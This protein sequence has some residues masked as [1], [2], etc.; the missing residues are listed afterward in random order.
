MIV[1]VNNGGA[2]S[3]EYF[4][5]YFQLL[6]NARQ[7]NLDEA[8]QYMIHQF[9]HLDPLSFGIATRDKYLEALNDLTQ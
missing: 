3:K 9:F 6:M 4:L 5:A 2:L 1:I 7:M 8:N